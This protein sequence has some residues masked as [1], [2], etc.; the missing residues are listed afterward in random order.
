MSRTQRVSASSLVLFGLFGL[1]FVLGACGS[2]D[3][4]QGGFDVPT[5]IPGEICVGC[6]DDADV[7][8]T[9]GEV[10]PIDGQGSGDDTFVPLNDGDLFFVLEQ[11]DDGQSCVDKE[12][13]TL[14]FEGPDVAD[15]EVRYTEDGVP[16]VDGALLRFRIKGDDF[17][18]T[19]L[20]PGTG[21]ASVDAEGLSGYLRLRV[22]FE[23][24]ALQE[25]ELDVEVSVNNRPDVGIITFHIII[26]PKPLPP[27]TVYPDY[28]GDQ[29]PESVAVRLYQQTADPANP[30]SYQTIDANGNDIS[31]RALEGFVRR[32]ESD[33]L[34]SSLLASNDLDFGRSAEFK[35]EVFDAIFG[36]DPGEFM[37]SI[38]AVGEDAN[39]VERVVGCDDTSALVYTHQSSPSSRMVLIMLEDLWP[40]LKGTYEVTSTFDLVS[41]LPNNIAQVVYF[42]VDFFEDPAF[43]ILA[44]LCELQSGITDSMCDW[45]FDEDPSGDLQAT[46]GGT[47]VIEIINAIVYG[48]GEGNT[49]GQI[50]VGGY[51]VGQ[52]LT[53]LR[54]A[55]RMTL[56]AEPD[57]ET[58]ELPANSTDEI[59]THL[60]YRWTLEMDPACQMDPDCGWEELSL[61][62]IAEEAV[63]GEFTGRVNIVEYNGHKP[64][65]LLTIDPHSLNIKYGQLVNYV[66]LNAILPRLA[67]GIPAD[68]L[69]VVDTWEELF[70]SLLAGR[71]CLADEIDGNPNTPTCCEAFVDSVLDEAGNTSWLEDIL[72]TGCNMIIEFGSLYIEALL[73]DQ[74]LDTGDTFVIGTQPDNPCLMWDHDDDLVVDTLGNPADEDDYCH[75]EVVIGFISGIDVTIDA[76]F[77]A[78]KY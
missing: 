50:L 58:G 17:S 3:A 72:S 9:S 28:A 21:L 55:S 60:R 24:P 23:G 7:V 45:V 73:T 14:I 47:I 29:E 62:A 56:S 19:S 39:G 10:K 76:T 6:Q 4:Q 53:N 34:P 33:Y 2:D 68:G 26:D 1:L 46:V 30:G 57:F 20:D 49:W 5:I 41:G 75:W 69:P 25:D 8:S 32:N 70:K 36:T 37:F 11:G 78:A 15:L 64:G 67:G 63:T 13:C 59:W 74:D 61:Q 65:T 31:C 66:F 44:L 16:P 71:E 42:I 27:L 54:M 38:L 48:L 35:E 18:Q 43:A 51:D 52:L 12:I 40:R 22:G 77:Y